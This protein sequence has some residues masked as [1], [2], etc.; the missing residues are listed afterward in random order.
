M[1]SEAQRMLLIKNNAGACDF[2]NKSQKLE[3][4]PKCFLT[5]R[6]YDQ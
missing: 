2:S 5:I 3:D 6:Y 4:R 1:R